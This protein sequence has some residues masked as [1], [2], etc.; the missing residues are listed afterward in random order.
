MQTCYRNDVNKNTFVNTKHSK[1]I[2]SEHFYQQFYFNIN[3]SQQDHETVGA[4]KI[5]WPARMINTAPTVP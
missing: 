5:T 1:T 4:M 2:F 3:N